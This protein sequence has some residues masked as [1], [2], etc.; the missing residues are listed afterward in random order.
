MRWT[1]ALLALTA[2]A[3]RTRLQTE[4]DSPFYGGV[5][6]AG[7]PDVGGSLVAGQ[8]FSKATARYDFAF[9]LR[10][11]YQ[12][13]EDSATQD[14]KFFQIQAGV[15]QVTSPGHRQRWV[16]RYGA[17]WFRATGDPNILELPGDYFGAF[18]GV[19]YEWYL[20]PRLLVGPEVVVNVVNGEGSTD[21]ELLPQLAL[22]LL[23]DF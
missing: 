7:L 23:F 20:S 22:N 18:G 11:T 17:T 8:W 1:L 5:A 14:G 10:G 15:K 3:C 16:F 6:L 19:G 9:E 21:W 2:V 4:R 13:A 12:R